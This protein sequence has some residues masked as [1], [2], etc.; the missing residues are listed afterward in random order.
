M[1]QSPFHTHWTKV[2][3]KR[4][5]SSPDDVE[6]EYKYAK[7]TQHWLHPPSASTTNRY[8]PLEEADEADR[9]HQTG[10]EHPPKPPPIM[11]QNVITI[12][13]FL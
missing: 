5:R 2:S 6:R 4:G 9:P 1:D 12:P 13:P 3:H 8:S 10:L 7:A 11:I